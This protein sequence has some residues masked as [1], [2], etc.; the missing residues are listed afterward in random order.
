MNDFLNALV[1]S[2]VD[3]D[4]ES[5]EFSCEEILNQSG[6]AEIEMVNVFWSGSDVDQASS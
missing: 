1:F 2:L 5:Y 6:Y 3:F 4:H